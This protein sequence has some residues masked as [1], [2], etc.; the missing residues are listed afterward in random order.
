MFTGVNPSPCPDIP[1]A[2]LA[3]WQRVVDIMARIMNVP[4]GLVM[5]TDPPDHLALVAS[6]GE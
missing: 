4:A 3:R 6:Q 1:P 5:R 2:S